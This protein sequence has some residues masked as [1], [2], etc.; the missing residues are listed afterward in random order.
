MGY[1]GAASR[2]ENVPPAC[3]TPVEVLMGMSG[4]AL[5]TEAG[6]ALSSPHSN[7]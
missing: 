4:G 7:M 3:V 2:A 5:S 1:G 6:E